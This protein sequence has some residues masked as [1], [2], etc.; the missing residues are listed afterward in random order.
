MREEP[1]CFVFL[2]SKRHSSACEHSEERRVVVV[3]MYN[4]CFLV[5]DVMEAAALRHVDG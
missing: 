2:I 3:V 1:S 5:H 4:L